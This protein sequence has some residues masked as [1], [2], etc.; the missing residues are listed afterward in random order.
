MNYGPDHNPVVYFP[1][2]FMVRNKLVHSQLAQ[3][4]RQAICVRF[5]HEDNQY[6]RVKNIERQRPTA[7]TIVSWPNPKQWVIVH[8]S[9][10]MMIIRQSIYIYIF[11]QSSQ[12]NWVNWKHSPTYCIMDNW[13]NICLILHTRQIISDRHFISSMSSDIVCTM[14]I[15]RWCNVQ[16]N[17]YDAQAKTYPTICTLLS[18]DPFL[19]ENWL[20]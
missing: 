6:V 1:W 3:P 17:E 7:H 4:Q 9:A 14:M 5:V 2:H 10:L 12:R 8:T 18:A 20:W 16:T 13:E 15:M 11:S 19:W